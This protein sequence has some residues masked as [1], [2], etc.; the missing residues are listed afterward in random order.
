MG[1]KKN[2]KK[3]VAERSYFD[4][5]VTGARVANPRVVSD[6]FV[7]FTLKCK[8][9]SLY[10]M[11]LMEF[12]DKKTGE[13]YYTVMPPQTLGRD[14]K[15]YDQYAIYLSPEDKAWLITEVQAALNE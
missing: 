13:P 6:T 4:L 10:N 15:Y 3:E 8:G 2:E 12:K 1:F 11:R 14:G 5:E 7:S 9:F